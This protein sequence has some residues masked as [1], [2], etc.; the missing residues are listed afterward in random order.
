VLE[1][2][3]KLN[4][5]LDN[6]FNS[7][8]AASPCRPGTH[9]TACWH[10]EWTFDSNGILTVS[11]TPITKPGAR[12]PSRRGSRHV[13]PLIESPLDSFIERTEP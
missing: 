10:L 7:L 2:P 11:A 12:S 5:C 1:N 8:Y 4:E 6:L 3:E 13:P 9:T